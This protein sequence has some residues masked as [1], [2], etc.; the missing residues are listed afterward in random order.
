MFTII[1][2]AAA[3]SAALVGFGWVTVMSPAAGHAEPP[4]P[5]GNTFNCPDIAGINYVQDPKDSQAYHLCID[6]S[7]TQHM[8]CPQVTKLIMGM[9]PK[10]MPFPHLMP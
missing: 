2:R 4:L 7:T 8:R 3:I 10:C 5:Q 6:G 1:E 9:L